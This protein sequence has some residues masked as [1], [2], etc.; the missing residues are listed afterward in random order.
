MQRT[1]TSLDECHGCG[2]FLS[3]A[4]SSCGECGA[5]TRHMSFDERNRYEAQQWRLHLQGAKG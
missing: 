1:M 2:A 4:Q 5:P 3:Q